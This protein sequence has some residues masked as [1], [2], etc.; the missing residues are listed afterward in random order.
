MLGGFCLLTT[1]IM[2]C[3]ALWPF[4]P[5]PKNEVAWL[6]NEDGLEFGKAGTLFSSDEFRSARPG[7]E[8]FCSLEIWLVPE[9]TQTRHSVTIFAFYVKYFPEQFVV[10]QLRDSFF[11][12]TDLHSDHNHIDAAEIEVRQG[13]RKNR[14]VL[15]TITS[16]PRGTS[17]Y[18]DGAF[19]D[20]STQ[21]GLSCRNFSGELVVGNS[22]VSYNPWQGKFL[23]LAIY[24]Q[25]LKSDQVLRHYLMWQ[26]G[27]ISDDAH[28]DRTVALYSLGER[29]GRAVHNMVGEGPDLYIPDTFKILDKPLLQTPWKEF[30]TDLGYSYDAIINVFGFVPFGFFV[31]AYMAASGYRTRVGVTAIVLG[32]L[33]SV[34]IEVL[35]K[36]IPVRD[37]GMTDV[38][39]NTIG[40]SIGVL[41]WKWRGPRPSIR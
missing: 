23:G 13:F 35:Q 5:N 26:R 21:F 36:F 12:S 15:F 3:A 28:A 29:Q 8:S 2:F 17:V 18:K 40:T 31:S 25:E 38:I 24:H 22:P 1:S 34:I 30:S 33:V 6:Q 32:T 7:G 10:R 14:K 27:T 9:F 11:V 41:F 20:N 4:T 19:V 37:S 39:T 16:G